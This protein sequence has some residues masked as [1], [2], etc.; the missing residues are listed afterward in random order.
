MRLAVVLMSIDCT[1]VKAAV[2]VVLRS[3][4]GV[5]RRAPLLR[6]LLRGPCHGGL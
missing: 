3:A 5:L 4:L 1:I 6:V 2:S